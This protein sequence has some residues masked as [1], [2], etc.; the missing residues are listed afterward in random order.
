MATDANG[1]AKDKEK[2][3][4]VVVL[5]YLKKRGYK[6][7]EMH[8]KQESNLQTVPLDQLT[9][10]AALDHDVSV[11]NYIM[12]YNSTESSPQRYIESYVKLREWI[13]SSLDLY[14]QEMLVIL[15]PVFVHCYLDLVSKGYS[16]EAHKLMDQVSPDHTEFHED[17]LKR[18]RGVTTP[19][20]V[21]ENELA[22]M[23]RNN[24]F[25]VTLSAYSF[26]LLL[27]FLNDARFMLLLSIVNQYLSIRVIQGRPGDRAGAVTRTE[28]PLTGQTEHEIAQLHAR[29]ILW[30]LFDDK[31]EEE[32]E[33]PDKPK[34]ESKKKKEGEKD[35]EK[36]EQR[37][38]FKS[39]VPLPRL[40]EQFE[41][42]IQE[43]VAK[44][45]TLSA[46]ALPSICFYTFFHTHRSLNTA[47]ISCDGSLVAGGFA[48]SSVRLWDLKKSAK[49]KEKKQ[50]QKRKLREGSDYRY[51]IGHS[52]PVFGCSLSPDSQFLLSCSEDTTVRLWSME[53]GSNV[54]CYKSHNYPVWDV[55]FSPLGY[56]FATA[57]HDRTARVW[58]TAHIT[59]LRILAGHLAD[60]TCVKFHPNINYVATG[61]ADKSLRLWEVH[62]GKCVR[63]FT[64]HHA[65]INSLSFSPDGR[66]LASAGDDRTIHIWDLATSR[67]L[68]R[69]AGH[70]R[71]VHSL[72][73]SAD[74]NLLASGAGDRT[75]KLWDVQTLRSA[76]QDA[77]SG[78]AMQL[79]EVKSFPSKHTPV[80]SVA[81]TRRNLLLASGPFL[82]QQ[83]QPQ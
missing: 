44:R 67:R 13:H 60:V 11:A 28:A 27:N 15:Y 63:I 7:A 73:F 49:E 25:N 45:V 50:V 40:S 38:K 54:V 33:K 79:N 29:D 24:K 53:T 83:A 21:L 48:D 8:F 18:L 64:G 78:D 12:F 39:A 69:L 23:F 4:D 34:K 14:K 9:S 66:L 82:P 10:N 32:E 35:K 74:G 59:P 75:V 1:V 55:S 57:S 56:Y 3:V 22:I 62:T 80:F 31:Q 71:A 76:M 58:A 61:S 16:E 42:E 46:T 36:E 65:T 43:D 20:H 77:P 2:D 52:G 72:D 41:N 37:T 47:E 51:L 26:D 30:G 17:E 68:A 70:T 5:N 19:A 81:F 6:Q